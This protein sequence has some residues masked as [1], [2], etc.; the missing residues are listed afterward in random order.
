MVNFRLKRAQRAATSAAQIESGIIQFAGTAAAG[1][2]VG[3]EENTTASTTNRNGSH[4]DCDT[5]NNSEIVENVESVGEGNPATAAAGKIHRDRVLRLLDSPRRKILGR[6]SSAGSGI[7]NSSSHDDRHSSSSDTGTHTGACMEKMSAAA[8]SGALKLAGG[9]AADPL[10]SPTTSSAATPRAKGGGARSWQLQQQ[11]APQPTSHDV[12]GCND[13][14]DLKMPAVAVAAA[15]AMDVDTSNTRMDPWTSNYYPV[16]ETNY[17]AATPPL[18]CNPKRAPHPP[19]SVQSKYSDPAN[20]LQWLHDEAPSDI[21]PRVLSYAGSRRISTLSLASRS[22][23]RLC[24]SDAVWRTACEDTGKYRPGV[25]PPLGPSTTWLQHYRDNPLVP[26]DYDTIPGALYRPDIQEEDDAT[27]R[28]HNHHPTVPQHRRNLRV[29]LQPRTYVLKEALVVHAL[30]RAEVTIETVDGPS[31][32]MVLRKKTLK[33][34]GLGGRRINPGGGL[35]ADFAVEAREDG[36]RRLDRS[37]SATSAASGSTKRRLRELLSCRSANGVG[38]DGG[39]SGDPNLSGT[40]LSSTS[41]DLSH[42]SSSKSYNPN[43]ARSRTNSLPTSILT[44]VPD[45]CHD[46]CYPKYA[47]RRAVLVLKTK[48]RDEPL[49]R[50]RQ[51]TLRLKDVACVH[52]THGTDIW[53]GNAAVQV[54]PPLDEAGE[55]PI[56][57]APP[58]VSATAYVDSCDITSLSGRGLVAI[59]GGRATVTDSHVHHCAATGIYIGGPTSRATVRGT[60]VVR[61]GFGNSR[62]GRR[63]V[64]RGHSGVYLEQ[65]MASLRDC[66]VSNN[67]LTG[68]SAVSADNALLDVRDSD[69]VSNEA[70]QLEMPP[71]GSRS[72]RRSISKDNRIVQEGLSRARSGLI[73]PEHAM[74]TSP[75]AFYDDAV[76]RS[77]PARTRERSRREPEGLPQSPAS[78][79]SSEPVG[80]PI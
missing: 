29:L 13:E 43:A 27:E 49:A 41:D 78:D 76:G 19:I 55:F 67:A 34:S 30:G 2:G 75:N 25:D 61:N 1:Q 68:I 50:V 45:L 46:G 17:L 59:D 15:E 37:A 16:Q 28:N 42:S 3:A 79:A 38:T 70:M 8:A 9:A 32:R 64:S 23:R 74:V 71:A 39:G 72:Y 31:E 12:D 7:A 22:W 58:H 35:C 69:L 60:D 77:G 66:N 44:Q 65:G 26:V 20:I 11:V 24:L 62:H 54:Q 53:N 47:K 80:S 33:T 14:G 36:A 10:P 21:L 63:G 6:M 40:G 73:P 57:T 48:K 18:L 52:N 56:E 4:S 5:D 51:G